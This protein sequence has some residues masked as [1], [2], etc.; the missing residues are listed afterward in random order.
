M[1]SFY[2]AVG[3]GS[4]NKAVCAS[5]LKG[6]SWIYEDI[7]YYAATER[8]PVFRPRCSFHPYHSHSTVPQTLK[9]QKHSAWKI[10][11]TL[12]IWKKDWEWRYE[13]RAKTLIQLLHIG[14]TPIATE[15]AGKV[16]SKILMR[17]SFRLTFFDFEVFPFSVQSQLSKL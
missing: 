2:C 14:V 7:S 8:R 4:L 10:K 5:S 17:W 11:F 13:V 6:W 1:K 16:G 3:T 15:H 9:N 12:V